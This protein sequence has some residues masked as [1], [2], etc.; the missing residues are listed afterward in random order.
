MAETDR[1]TDKYRDIETREAI[2]YNGYT[3]LLY[4][5]I[6]QPVRDKNLVANAE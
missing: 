3:C 4:C 6:L 5:I 1:K 2:I